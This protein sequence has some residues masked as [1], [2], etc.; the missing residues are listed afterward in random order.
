M[1]EGSPVPGLVE[2]RYTSPIW[3]KGHLSQKGGVQ[4]ISTNAAKKVDLSATSLVKKFPCTVEK[5]ALFPRVY[6]NSMKVRDLL[7]VKY[8][9]GKRDFTLQVL[10][11]YTN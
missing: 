5:P 8:T 3:E 2:I 9:G 6:I 4:P 7:R 10:E 11:L 1:A